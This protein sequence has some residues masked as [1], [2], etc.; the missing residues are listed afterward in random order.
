MRFSPSR[1]SRPPSSLL[2][3]PPSNCARISRRFRDEIPRQI[4]YS[5]Q[6]YGC[7]SSLAESF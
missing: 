1:S 4:G 3:A 5:L 6:S 7:C 2:I